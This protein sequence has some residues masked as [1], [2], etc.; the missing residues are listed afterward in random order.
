MRRRRLWG[1]AIGWGLLLLGFAV[2]V[3]TPITPERVMVPLYRYPGAVWLQVETGAPT[4]QMTIVNPASGPGRRPDSRFALAV[5]ALERKFLVLGYVATDYGKIPISTVMRQIT[6][7]FDWYHV[8]GIF[9]DNTT[10]SCQAGGP[11]TYY[12][13]VS[14]TIRQKWPQATIVMN[15]GTIPGACYASQASILVTYEGPWKGYAQYRPQAWMLS[16]HA[17]Q[18]ANLISRL[19]GQDV[20]RAAKLAWER[21][22][23]WLYLTNRGG[24]GADNAYDRLPSYFNAE[25]RAVHQ[26]PWGFLTDLWHR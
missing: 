23:G 15:P 17:S 1:L 10:T 5:Q 11:I 18:F 9:L 3:R 7:Y 21:H 22:A 4:V 8:N 16:D 12:G 14:R 19:P 24:R 20:A 2:W 26:L 6:A 13:A 25:V